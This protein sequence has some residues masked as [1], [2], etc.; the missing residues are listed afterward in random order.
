MAEPKRK[1][2]KVALPKVKHLQKKGR[3]NPK[4]E[5]P[6]GTPKVLAAYIQFCGAMR[7][8]YKPKD[9]NARD[10]M[11]ERGKLWQQATD[12]EKEPLEIVVPQ[13][14]F[15]REAQLEARRRQTK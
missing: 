4:K 15:P 3:K 14:R 11:I 6:V 9:L 12:A 5:L 8:M 10:I 13:E 7:P 2:K 1:Q